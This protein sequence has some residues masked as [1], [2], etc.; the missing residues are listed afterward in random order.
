MKRQS[1]T[2]KE[3]FDY[4]NFLSKSDIKSKKFLYQKY[5]TE[6]SFRQV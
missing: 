3:T 5:I 1:P 6:C 4:Y 2:R